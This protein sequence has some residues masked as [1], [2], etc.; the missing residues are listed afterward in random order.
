M[1]EE[2]ASNELSTWLST[3]GLVTTERILEK[4]K[5]RLPQEELV[6]AIKNPNTFYHHLI[7]VPLKNVLNG[8]ILQ[9]AY[10]YQVYAQKLFIDYLMSGET[11]KPEE[12][13]GGLT[14]EDLEKERQTL[15]EMSDEF[16]KQE[17]AHDRVIAESQASLIKN[18][19][20]WQECLAKAA[21][22]VK[23]SP[24]SKKI[25]ED[26]MIQAINRLLIQLGFSQEKSLTT[27][28]VDWSQIEKIVGQTTSTDLREA[29]IEQITQL[30]KFMVDTENLL[31]EFIERISQM[32][33]KLRKY[34]T[35]FY[36]II[37]RINDLIKNLPEYRH[38]NVQDQ[39]NRESLH[40]D[41][42]IGEDR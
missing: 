41:S 34:R 15:V 18:S 5:I 20:E 16:H 2:K 14:R 22:K 4:Y 30:G 8:I 29:F 17:L 39:E 42:G 9:Q 7:R 35:D 26:L 10:D 40:F 19:D 21:K 6:T 32:S 27:K 13:P 38:D 28:D 33:L 31:K 3:Y 12:S 36:D 1:N 25:K 11:A 23:K 24:E 37:I